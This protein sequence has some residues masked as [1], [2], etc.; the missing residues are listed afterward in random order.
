MSEGNARIMINKLLSDSE[1]KLPGHDHSANVRTEVQNSAGFADYVL[2][3][4]DDFPICVIE[5][6]KE[7]LSP[8][9]N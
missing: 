1:W 8:L 6:K 4:D 9:W 7:L 2:F 3:D 5:A